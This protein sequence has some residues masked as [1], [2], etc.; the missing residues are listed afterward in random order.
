MFVRVYDQDSGRY[1]KSI[2]YGLIDCG[3]FEQAI[4][5]DPYANCFKL[6][7]YLQKA[8]PFPIAIYE[9]IQPDRKDWGTS[10]LSPDNLHCDNRPVDRFTGFPDVA[11][12]AFL[13]ALLDK[14]CVPVELSGIRLRSLE[15]AQHWNY[16]VTQADADAFM[17]LFQGFHDSTLDKLIYEEDQQIRKV[18][19]VF[20]NSGWYGVAELCFEGLIA[21]NLRPAQ[22][23]FDR[24][25]FDGTLIVKDEC[26]FWA[27][28]AINEEDLSYEGSFIKA[29]NLKW[30][31]IG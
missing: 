28:D 11:N 29:L 20:D 23:N 9:V 18:T 13:T 22:E 7:H 30:R 5:V 1:Y 14:K 2:V 3:F 12:P 19:A 21:M 16:I 27:D 8:D 17:D 6:V 25:I 26:I 31:K 4:V 15:D 24:Y 10:Q